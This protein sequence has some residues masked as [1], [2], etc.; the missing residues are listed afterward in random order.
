MID[1]LPPRKKR[2]SSFYAGRKKTVSRAV[3][4]KQARLLEPLPGRREKDLLR[5]RH[6]GLVRRLPPPHGGPTKSPGQNPTPTTSS[7][8]EAVREIS[9]NTSCKAAAPFPPDRPGRFD[10][11]DHPGALSQTDSARAPSLKE[12]G[13]LAVLGLD[14]ELNRFI[15]SGGSSRRFEDLAEQVENLPLQSASGST[16]PIRPACT[17]SGARKSPGN[18]AL[19]EQAISNC[20]NTASSAI[21]TWPPVTRARSAASDLPQARLSRRLGSRR[22]Y[23]SSRDNS[24]RC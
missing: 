14:I 21:S 15:R 19:P 11:G 3:P 13:G 5:F 12:S 17:V 16:K 6:D 10:P 8:W 24:T 4:E 7:T 18:G 9:S 2:T 1:P 22:I 23:R 20:P